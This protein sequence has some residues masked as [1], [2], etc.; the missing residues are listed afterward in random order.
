MLEE[1]LGRGKLGKV[2]GGGGIGGGGGLL[3][4]FG[5]PMRLLAV[6][7]VGSGLRPFGAGREWG[8]T[9]ITMPFRRSHSRR[10]RRAHSYR[11][12]GSGMTVYRLS[13]LPAGARRRTRPSRLGRMWNVMTPLARSR[14]VGGPRTRYLGVDRGEGEVSCGFKSLNRATLDDCRSLG[15]RGPSQCPLT[16]DG[17]GRDQSE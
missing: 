15:G 6:R 7:G 9:I 12:V 10:S 3:C 1:V 5:P 14:V 17:G 2:E 8:R 11:S 13:S 16:L 4:S